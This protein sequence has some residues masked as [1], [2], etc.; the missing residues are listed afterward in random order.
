MLRFTLKS[1]N[2]DRGGKLWTGQL[3]CV[4]MSKVISLSFDPTIRW[5]GREITSGYAE[6]DPNTPD[7]AVNL[8]DLKKP[9]WG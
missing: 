4:D 9:E 6:R 3:F 1:G 7:S 8:G 5:P 2:D